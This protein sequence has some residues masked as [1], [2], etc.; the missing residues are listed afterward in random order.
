MAVKLLIQPLDLSQF[1]QTLT[2]SNPGFGDLATSELGDSADPSDGFDQVVSD[3][4]G[5]IDSLDTATAA[6][7]NDLITILSLLD[8]A[9]L[10]QADQHLDDYT[11]TVPQG[12]ALLGDA[13][14]IATPDLGLVPIVMPDGSSTITLGGAPS[15]GGSVHQGDPAY[16]L[17]FPMPGPAGGADV[18]FPGSMDGPNPPFTGFVGYVREPGPLGQNQWH[19]L[20]NVNPTAVGS[21]T[22]TLHLTGTITITGIVAPFTQSTPLVVIVL[23]AIVVTPPPPPPPP[24]PPRPFV[25]PIFV[26]PTSPT[27][28]FTVVGVQ[29]NGQPSVVTALNF[30]SVIRYGPGDS[31]E[32]DLAITP[33]GVTHNYSF[34][35]TV[36]TLGTSGVAYSDDFPVSGVV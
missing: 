35:I 28:N 19:A 6:A 26:T 5:L 24:P 12:D 3:A 33:D 11:A 15:A 13:Q 31:V 32:V 22:A 7:D 14:G 29:G 25:R 34:T 20:I 27:E 10:Q 1:D 4:L 9:L 16:V 2:P 18:I 8:A 17:H 30:N 36:V 21:F 23:P